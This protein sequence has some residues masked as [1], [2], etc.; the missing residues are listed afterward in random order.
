MWHLLSSLRRAAAPARLLRVSRRGRRTALHESCSVDPEFGFKICI[1]S[2]GCMH[3]ALD[4]D[5]PGEF[6]DTNVDVVLNASVSSGLND[7]VSSSR[8]GVSG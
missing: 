7:H 6:H 4:A 3:Y 2:S 8:C 1:D 5:G